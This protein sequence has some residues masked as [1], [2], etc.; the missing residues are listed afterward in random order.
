MAER[1]ILR[2]PRSAVSGQRTEDGSQKPEDRRRKTLRSIRMA[3]SETAAKPGDT[4]ACCAWVFDPAPALDRRSPERPSASHAQ[5]STRYFQSSFVDPNRAPHVAARFSLTADRWPLT[6]VRS[7]FTLIELL[8]V[9]AISAT[10]AAILLPALKGARDRAYTAVCANQLRQI[11]FGLVMYA[12][13]YDRCYPPLLY[14]GTTTRTDP[15]MSFMKSLPAAGGNGYVCWLWLLY[16]YHH[17]PEI[18]ICPS[19]K[20]KLSRAR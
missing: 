18:Y 15:A 17:K 10:L 3:R 2:Q 14:D 11:N 4:V 16:P 12:D 9:V 13:D 20:Y 7:A 19:A 5:P 6:T 1:E 8:V